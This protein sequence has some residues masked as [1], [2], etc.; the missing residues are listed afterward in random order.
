MVRSPRRNIDVGPGL[1]IGVSDGDRLYGDL[2][3]SSSMCKGPGLFVGTTGE[4]R[5]CRS[6]RFVDTQ[7]HEPVSLSQY[8]GWGRSVCGSVG[9]VTHVLT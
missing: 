8:P 7:T 1:F 2:T 5:P 3:G 6:H 9:W 4:D